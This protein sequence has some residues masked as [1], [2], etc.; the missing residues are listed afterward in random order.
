M[1]N[2]VVG[3][4]IF[5]SYKYADTDV[6]SL[7]STP[8]YEQTK[9]RDYVNELAILLSENGHTYMGE[10]NDED[11]SN[12]SDDYIYDHLKD[13]IFPTSVTIVLISPNM[14][15]AHRLDRFQWIPWE[16]YYSIY[17]TNRNGRISHTNAILAVVLPDQ[18]GSYSY[19][20]EQ[21]SCCP[22][23]CRLLHTESLFTILKENMFNQKE[24]NKQDCHLGDNVYKGPCSYIP[25]VKWSDFIQNMDKYLEQAEYT[26]DH[27]EEYEMHRSVNK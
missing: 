5:V 8:W 19:M 2:V 17:E 26:R 7:A 22:S 12:Y 23:R 11:L 4:N 14:K 27:I 1:I 9:V 16:I 25:M 3:R 24:K 20:V 15:E 13:K 18:L 21:K 6:Q 10:G